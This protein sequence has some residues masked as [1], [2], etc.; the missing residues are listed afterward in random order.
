[1]KYGYFQI[2]SH[3]ESIINA[4][5]Y[6]FGLLGYDLSEWKCHHFMC[7]YNSLILS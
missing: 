1:M 5:A 2:V 4:E 6:S 3:V 7:F